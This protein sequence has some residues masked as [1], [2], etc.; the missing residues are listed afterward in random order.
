MLRV[1]GRARN[2][3]NNNRLAEEKSGVIP[4]N[5]RQNQDKGRNE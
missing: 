4:L 3:S 5:Y 2:N 1:K